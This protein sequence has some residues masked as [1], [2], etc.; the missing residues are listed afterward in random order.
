MV[1]LAFARCYDPD[2]ARLYLVRHGK[3][4]AG[5]SEDVDPGL[6]DAGREQ[7][8]EVARKLAPLGPLLI[9]S[10]PLA[11]AKETAAPLAKK[12]GVGLAIEK[13]VSEI[14]SPTTDLKGRTG[15]LGKLM[16][17]EWSSV[18]PEL[19]TW[20]KGVINTLLE[21]EKDAVVF[22]HFIAVNAAT[23]AAV[24][25]GRVVCFSPGYGSVTVMEADN[26]KLSLIE[27]GFEASSRVV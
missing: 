12:W 22:T 20:R 27:R 5:W 2:M 25:D 21:L 14:P 13:R 19:E 4:A 18:E 6:D 8:E 26:G 16:T 7:A 10:S 3:A 17:S 15:W 23:G 1:E 9:I 11:R 24:G